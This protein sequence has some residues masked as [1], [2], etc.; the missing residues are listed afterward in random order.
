[1]CSCVPRGGTALLS[2][3]GGVLWI[4]SCDRNVRSR[5]GMLIF[6]PGCLKWAWC[7]IGSRRKGAGLLVTFRY[8]TAICFSH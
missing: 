2:A 3:T 1:M 6:S 4:L 7:S 5:L 8:S